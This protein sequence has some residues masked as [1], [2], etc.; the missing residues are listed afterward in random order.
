MIVLLKPLSHQSTDG[1]V[2][3]STFVDVTRGGCRIGRVPRGGEEA[4]ASAANAATGQLWRTL[5]W[6]MLH[7]T[8]PQGKRALSWTKP[9]DD[10]G[11]RRL[12]GRG[13]ARRPRGMSL[14]TEDGACLQAVTGK[15]LQRSHT[16]QDPPS[17]CRCSRHRE[18]VF[19]QSAFLTSC[20][21]WLTLDRACLA[22]KGVALC[23]TDCLTLL[24]VAK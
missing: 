15:P 13:S 16:S 11:G 3:S 1:S 19:W 5:S 18:V 2:V 17:F 14:R 23:R 21:T 10:R 7:W 6:G 24:Y 22:I 20:R 4:G 9:W 12:R 8:R